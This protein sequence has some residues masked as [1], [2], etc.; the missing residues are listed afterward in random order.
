[1]APL[2]L[3]ATSL[4][5]AV[6]VT[7]L[8]WGPQGIVRQFCR[9]DGLGRRVN[10]QGWREVAPLVTWPFEPAWDHVV[11]ISGYEVGS[12]RPDDNGVLAVDVRYAVIGDLS[13]L[14]L[15]A[16]THVETATFRVHAPS[17]A[18]WRIIGPPPPPHIF[19]SRVDVD[20]M[21]R[22]LEHGGL[23]FL[24]NTMF[25]WQMFRSAGWNVA[26]QSTADLLGGEVYRA[27]DEPK[28][29]DVVVYLRDGK[30]YH[31]GVLEAENQVV[32][33]TLNAGIVRTATDA[34]PGEVKYM[35]LLQPESMAD[36]PTTPAAHAAV[37]RP[38][39]AVPIPLPRRTATPA[40][41]KGKAKPKK[42]ATGA[43]QP[44]PTRRVERK[45]K[46]QRRRS[47][48]TPAAMRTP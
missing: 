19:A 26:F 1:M 36:V 32:S 48:P 47:R 42:S 4:F 44:S 21:R 40:L 15:D 38:P 6:A 20:K 35:R 16:E 10:L 22:S 9:A 12:P 5:G 18:G 30:P 11:L 33:S 14:D 28:A 34:F 25:V 46:S 37:V 7:A 29:G 31:V 41:R 23:N 39:A 43:A 24:A 3:L 2:L 45:A 8:E 27:I 17:D 13:A